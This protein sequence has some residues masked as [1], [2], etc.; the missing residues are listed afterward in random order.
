MWA[1]GVEIFAFDVG[2]SPQPE[3]DS[4][5]SAGAGGQFELG[6]VSGEEISGMDEVLHELRR[7][8]RGSV[9]RRDDDDDGGSSVPVGFR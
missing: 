4:D 6:F 9:R 3:S 7:I 8:K 2:R 1:L 5:G